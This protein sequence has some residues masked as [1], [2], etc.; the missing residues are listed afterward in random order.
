MEISL[1]Q[2][3]FHNGQNLSKFINLLLVYEFGLFGPFGI[4]D[5]WYQHFKILVFTYI[6]F[7]PIPAI[8]SDFQNHIPDMTLRIFLRRLRHALA[9]STKWS[10]NQNYVDATEIFSLYFFMIPVL[11]AAYTTS[12]IR[13]YSKNYKQHKTVCLRP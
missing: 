7:D 6:G 3:I 10:I 8:P 9:S 12:Y 13:M 2:Q 4:S 5:Q 1:L 11:S